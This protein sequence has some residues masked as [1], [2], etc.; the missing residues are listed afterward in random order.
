ME[1]SEFLPGIPKRCLGFRAWAR[2]NYLLTGDPNVLDWKDSRPPMPI[3]KRIAATHSVELK[4]TGQIVERK[5]PP[6]GEVREIDDFH[7][8]FT[9]IKNVIYTNIF[10]YIYNY[11]FIDNM[12]ICSISCMIC[13]I[14]RLLQ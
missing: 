5:R 2:R 12:L 1:P 11:T 8:T 9:L 4:E 14:H 7:P 3:Q 10:K 6:Q 13:G